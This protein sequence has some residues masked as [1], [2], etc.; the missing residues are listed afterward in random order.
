MGLRHLLLLILLACAAISS[1]ARQAEAY[2]KWMSLPSET[3]LK[4][5][6]AYSG[7]QTKSDSALICYTIVAVDIQKI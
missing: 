3:L 7:Q 2:S 4:M 6:R 1:A 5:A